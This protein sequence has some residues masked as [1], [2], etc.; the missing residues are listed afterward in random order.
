MCLELKTSAKSL[1]NAFIISLNIFTFF[2]CI[3]NSPF[4][5]LVRMQWNILCGFINSEY[6]LPLEYK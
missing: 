1:R 3:H 6:F 2:S 5:N 4:G